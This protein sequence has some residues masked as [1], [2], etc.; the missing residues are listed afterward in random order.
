MWGQ[1]TLALH[2]V[3]V[4]TDAADQDIVDDGEAALAADPVAA[5][6]LQ[7]TVGQDGG[8]VEAD[9]AAVLGL[10]QGQL[11]GMEELPN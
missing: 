6:V 3:S 7:A 11:L 10:G 8:L 9:A 2:A 5:T 1:L 4:D